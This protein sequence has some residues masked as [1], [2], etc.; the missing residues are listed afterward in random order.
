MLRF[1][2]RAFSLFFKNAAGVPDGLVHVYTEDYA[3]GGALFNSK[4]GTMTVRRTTI[5]D[6]TA[7]SA[8]GV[9]AG[10]G[11]NSHGSLH[12]IDSLL[13]NNTAFGSTAVN[14]ISQYNQLHSGL[15]VGMNEEQTWGYGGGLYSR[16]QNVDMAGRAVVTLTTVEGT[17][18]GNNTASAEGGGVYTDGPLTM[19]KTWVV[20][21]KVT[22]G[23]FAHNLKAT[24]GYQQ[25]YRYEKDE[26]LHDTF[27]WVYVCVC[28]CVCVVVVRASGMQLGS[29]DYA[30][31]VLTGTQR[32]PLSLLFGLVC[33][34]LSVSSLCL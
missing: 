26:P 33:H 3:Y 31:I 18:V 2:A 17:L 32:C 12:V 25:T 10:G 1:V 8:L 21:N 4:D 15:T 6:N 34:L 28:V 19:I 22:N 29:G 14:R 11:V 27:Q 16:V 9:G 20:N 5:R 23:D 13:E 7:I 24:S 30:R